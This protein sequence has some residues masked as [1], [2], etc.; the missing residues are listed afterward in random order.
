MTVMIL[1]LL[2][3]P[4]LFA[5]LFHCLSV[6]M[7]NAGIIDTGWA[8]AVI[9]PSLLLGLNSDVY[10]TRMY[11]VLFLALFWALRLSFHLYF[12][13]I[14]GKSEEP[15]YHALRLKW[16][17]QATS[18]MFRFF[19][20]QGFAASFFAIPFLLIVA[21]TSSPLSK[22]EIFA[23]FGW[24]MAL[25]G[26]ALADEQL[27]AHKRNLDNRGKTCRRGLW[28]Y[29]RHPNYFFEWLHW[30]FVALLALSA[31]WGFIALLHPCVI[32]H[33]L[34]RV[35]GIPLA[36]EQALK[37]RGDDYRQYQATTSAFFLWF[38]KK[39]SK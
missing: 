2:L 5:L 14:R 27:E 26:E 30:C 1:Y 23:L 39:I 8:L 28:Q 19:L 34:N 17:D 22:L 36:E 4:I 21:D 20:I 25:A 3:Q 31:P 7:N 16:A 38:P 35:S 18:K 37:S 15:R 33:F 13:R 11:A 10:P 12:R 9:F 6:K 24:G 32:W 29:S